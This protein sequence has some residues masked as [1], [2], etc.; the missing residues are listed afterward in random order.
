MFKCVQWEVR[1]RIL[2]WWIITDSQPLCG[3]PDEGFITT[4]YI[5][6]RGN[7]LIEYTA[8]HILKYSVPYYGFKLIERITSQ[9]EKNERSSYDSLGSFREEELHLNRQSSRAVWR[10]CCAAIYNFNTVRWIYLLTIR[11]L[12]L[13]GLDKTAARKTHRRK[14]SW[15]AFRIISRDFFLVIGV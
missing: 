11:D 5:S 2:T 8:L 7:I 9:V 12:I 3:C 1:H 14:V 4:P 13:R 10:V 6:W 15:V